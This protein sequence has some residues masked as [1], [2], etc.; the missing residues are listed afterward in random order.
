MSPTPKGESPM[1]HVDFC[2]SLY[3]LT[4]TRLY[5]QYDS[6]RL[7]QNLMYFVEKQGVTYAQFHV[8][9]IFQVIVV[10]FKSIYHHIC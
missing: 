6:S 8:N 5:V 7:L 3:Y 2:H 1:F 9:P 4:V 10:Y